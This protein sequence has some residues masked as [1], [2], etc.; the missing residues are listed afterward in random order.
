MLTHSDR[1]S[2]SEPAPPMRPSA[3]RPLRGRVS[4]GHVVMVV[5]GLLG[6][7][8]SLSVLRRADT[9]VP[10]MSVAH[11]LAPGARV[12]PG[13]FRVTRVH[14]DP[15]PLANLVTPA[16]LAGLRGDIVRAPLRAGDL[17]ERSD[18]VAAS[19]GRATR[20]V[21]FPVDAS[22]AV[23]GDVAAG[24]RIDVLASATDGSASGYVL[25]GAD[26]VA[27]HSSSSGPL[28]AGD[29]Q[30][31]IT[32][33]VDSAGTER[34]AAALHGTD[35]LVVRSTGAAAVASAHWFTSGGTDG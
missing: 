6:L 2:R 13:L 20:S 32:V 18:V 14:V 5:A 27:V 25:V 30:I 19:T 31:T 28:R 8:L 33:A 17:L 10:V 35:L 1:V 22:L 7:L 16:T 26:V 15:G 23:D 3:S 9:T 21:S 4:S 24:D 34:L 11:D 29:G 12:E